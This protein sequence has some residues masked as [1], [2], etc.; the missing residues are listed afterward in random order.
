MGL[1]LRASLAGH[2]GLVSRLI[3]GTIGVI[4]W[5]YVGYRGFLPYLRSLRDPP[6]RGFCYDLAVALSWLLGYIKD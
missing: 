5:V 2:G 6:G 4:M 3:L 1:G